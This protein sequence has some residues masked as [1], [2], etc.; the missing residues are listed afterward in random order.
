MGGDQSGDFSMFRGKQMINYGANHEVDSKSCKNVY[1][2]FFTVEI[3]DIPRT[4][5]IYFDPKTK[6]VWGDYECIDLR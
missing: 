6:K 2:L 3:K 5:W 1:S 4:W